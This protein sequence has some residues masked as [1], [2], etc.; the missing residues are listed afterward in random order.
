MS[1]SIFFAPLQGYTEAI[2]RNAH[3]S[4]FGGIEAYYTPFVRFEKNIFRPKDIRE[5]SPENNSVPH[6]IPQLLASKCDQAESI[7]ALFIEKGYREVDLNL[8]CPFPLLA[9]RH[10]GSGLLPHSEEVEALLKV[11]NNHPDIQFSVKM[12]LGWEDSKECLNAL[13]ILNDLPLKHICLHPRIGKQ[14][15]KGEVDMNGFT[16]FYEAC[17][18]P[19]IYNGDITSRTEIEELTQRFPKLG[20]VMIGR[21]LLANPALALEYQLG[22]SLDHNDLIQRTRTLHQEVFQRYQERLE[23][24][25]GQLLLKMK[26]FW[27]YLLPEAPKKLK[28]G[29]LKST[30][31]PKYEQAVALFWRG[32]VIE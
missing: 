11:V 25:D 8:G 27:E 21:G 26:A 22:K 10:Y 4:V 15:Y 31:L 17:K 30:T 12:R 14:Q 19:I 20:G 24:G 29:I 23:G 5:I 2:Y 32:A 6:L 3:A 18:H 16:T 7:L 13:S 1:Q 9:K 28:K